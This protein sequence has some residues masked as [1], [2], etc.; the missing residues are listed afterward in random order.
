[1]KKS[2]IEMCCTAE[3]TDMQ[4]GMKEMSS[5]GETVHTVTDQI[6]KPKQDNSLA[7]TDAENGCGKAHS[8]GK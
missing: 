7:T 3:Q 2:G 6:L 4:M 5:L 8:R 1:M